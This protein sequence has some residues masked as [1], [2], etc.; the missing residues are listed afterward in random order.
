MI[1]E[2]LDYE[3]KVK[4]LSE[5]TIRAYGQDMRTFAAY[6]KHQTEICAWR[7]VHRNAIDQYLAKLHDYG[8]KPA[9]IRRM[10]ST[11]R[12][13]Y[14]YAMKK[15]LID[16]NPAR[17]CEMPK[18][19]R[20]LPN[21]IEPEAIEAYIDNERNPLEM[22]ALVAL[23]YETGVRIS[24]AL[25]IE[26]R[27]VNAREHSIRIYGKGLKTRIVYYG[28]RTQKTMNAYLGNRRGQ[29]FKGEQRNYR[30]E[31]WRALKGHSTN[32]TASPH[33]IRHTYATR[34]LNQGMPLAALQMLL[35]HA[36]PETTGIYAHIAQTTVKTAYER[37]QA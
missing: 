24:E 36:K 25:A 31:I 16:K 32:G 22:R 18:R 10:L 23:L 15:E 27:D 12:C 11:I 14:N 8:W 30:W 34:M 7:D 1:Q 26:T 37:A 5:N 6:L 13:F 28:Y 4:N 21:T 20:N 35:G 2:F 3:R 9:S 19:P 29:I 17:Y 33:M